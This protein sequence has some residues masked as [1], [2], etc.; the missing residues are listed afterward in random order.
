MRA[1][2]NQRRVLNS[3]RGQ[4]AAQDNKDLVAVPPP[5]MEESSRRTFAHHA[6]TRRLGMQ[7]VGLCRQYQ[8]SLRSSWRSK[9]GRESKATS[10]KGLESTILLTTKGRRNTERLMR[11]DH[12][13]IIRRFTR[14]RT[15]PVLSEQCFELMMTCKLDSK[16]IPGAHDPSSR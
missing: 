6:A 8:R 7:R 14:S 10:A 12:P 5:V 3:R 4:V 15:S 2:A 16:H 13:S 1:H 9:Q 11:T